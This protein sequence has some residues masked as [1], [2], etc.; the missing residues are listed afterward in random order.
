MLRMI[1][2]FVFG[3]VAVAELFLW[4]YILRKRRTPTGDAVVVVA[5]NTH[6]GDFLVALPFFQRI[7]AFYQR[8]LILVSDKRIEP[9]AL[10]SGCFAQVVP[11]EHYRFNLLRRMQTFWQLRQLNAAVVI[12]KYA[13]Y[14]NIIDHIFAAV[15]PAK[16]KFAVQSVQGVRMPSGRWCFHNKMWYKNFT[17]LYKYDRNLSLVG[18]ENAFADM[19]CGSRSD[20]PVGDLSCFEPLPPPDETLGRYALFV[21]GADNP[22]RRWEAEKFAAA[23][24]KV[25]NFQSELKLLFSGSPADMAVIQQIYDAL[26]EDLRSRAFIRKPQPDYLLSVKQLMSDVKH[27]ALVL[28]NDTGPLHIAAK[29][30][31]PCLCITG[32]WHWG[33]FLPCP[34]YKNTVVIHHKMACYNCYGACRFPGAPFGCLREVT[35]DMVLQELEK[36]FNSGTSV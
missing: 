27:A 31:V 18:N 33:Y 36:F 2:D 28:T 15:I 1:K 8:K 9:L 19:I 10:A 21:P 24:I 23:A 13:L 30:Q 6:L 29:C 14:S 3:I 34:E 25:L 32:G 20:D 5:A 22:N 17:V 16:I 26:P 11:A 4:Q 35:V 7:S 12:C